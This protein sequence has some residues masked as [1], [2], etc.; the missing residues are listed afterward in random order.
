MSIRTQLV[1]SLVDINEKIFFYPKLKSFYTKQLQGSQPFIVDVGSNKGQSID[2]F[3]NIHKN[4]D[5]IAFEPNKKLYNRLVSK[6]KQRS[7]IQLFNLGVSDKTGQ[8]TFHENV[9]DETSTFEELNYDSPYLKKKAAILGVN[10][11]EIIAARYVVEVT[12]LHSFISEH[13]LEKIDVLKIDVEGHEYQCLKGLFASGKSACD[14]RFI[15]IE[16]HNDDMY[17]NKQPDGTI[18]GLLAQNNFHEAIRIKHGLGDFHE[19]IYEHSS[20]R[21]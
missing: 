3:L 19:I 6:Y 2:F 18:E 8:L 15:Q 10:P 7:N 9:M 20:F 4:A 5:V 14:I 17:K 12:D 13:Q 1:Q 11:E 16:S 21:Q